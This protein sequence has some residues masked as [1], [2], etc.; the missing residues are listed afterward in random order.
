MSNIGNDYAINRSWN[1][2]ESY[3]D[4]KINNDNE[5]NNIQEHPI[6]NENNNIQESL[7]NEENNN[8]PES[9]NNEEN[10]N[11]QELRIN[12]EQS[13]KCTRAWKTA[14][15]N[16]CGKTAIIITGGL[17]VL[18]ALYAGVA[19]IVSLSK[20]V[21][22]DE[23]V[24]VLPFNNISMGI[25]NKDV[26]ER[27]RFLTANVAIELRKLCDKDKPISWEVMQSVLAQCPVLEKDEK[28]L[29]V[30]DKFCKDFSE[31]NVNTWLYDFLKINDMDVFNAAR[32]HE[33]DI[34][35]VTEFMQNSST[36]NWMADHV[37]KS[38]DLLDIGM[39]RFPTK[40]D[41]YIKLY[42]LQLSG[43]FSGSSYIFASYGINRSL[44][45]T[46]YACKYYPRD[47]LL[48]CLSPNMIKTTLV[49]FEHM[50]QT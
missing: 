40:T 17:I 11:I 2:N 27:L 45:V 49:N 37:S 39:I 28:E 23:T 47:E 14:W 18:T 5:K 22:K 36:H 21:T 20:N 42:R 19:G 44:S 34:K 25:Y 9:L 50:L 7:N 31:A 30:D 8:I 15:E 10:N 48:K 33:S 29:R 3:F 43:K 38:Y 24:H 4:I 46:V 32:I 26:D 41:P 6:H 16:K 12:N 13:S 35:K 1:E